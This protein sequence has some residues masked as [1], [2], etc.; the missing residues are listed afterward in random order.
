MMGHKLILKNYVGEMGSDEKKN[1]KIIFRNYQ[2]ISN[3][4]ALGRTKLFYVN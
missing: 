2:F 1:I 3:A 4:M